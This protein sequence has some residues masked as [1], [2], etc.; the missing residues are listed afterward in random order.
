MLTKSDFLNYLQCI[1]KLWLS[2]NRKDL[3][4]ETDYNLQKLFDQGYE[5]EQFAYQL[6]PEGISAKTDDFNQSAKKTKELIKTGEKVIFQPTFS[7]F[8]KNLYCRSDI[9]KLNEIPRPARGKIAHEERFWDIYEVKSATTVNDQ[10]IYD[11]AF[12][13]ICLEAEGLL[14]GKTFLIHLSNKYVRKGEI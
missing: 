4:P 11:L 7:N 9:I 6:F 13:K 12:Q 3:V 14:I 2:K 10:N 1:K 5:V 8:E